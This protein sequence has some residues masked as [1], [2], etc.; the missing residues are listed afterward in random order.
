MN[1]RTIWA[2]FWPMNFFLFCV[3]SVEMVTLDNPCSHTPLPNESGRYI[4]YIEEL[5]KRPCCGC[6]AGEYLRNFCSANDSSDT[7]CQACPVGTCMPFNA[8]FNHNCI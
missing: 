5:N 6:N 7:D 2:Y 1:H 3:G 4:K 8:H